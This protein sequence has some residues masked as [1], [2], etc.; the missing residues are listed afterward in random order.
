[1]N[2][3]RTSRS[4]FIVPSNVMKADVIYCWRRL[5]KAMLNCAERW[6]R[7]FLRTPAHGIAFKP[8]SIL[9]FAIL[10]FRWSAK[11]YLTIEFSTCSAAAEW[12]WCTEERTSSSDVRP[13]LNFYQ[14]NL[15]TI[16]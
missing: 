16:P 7:C 10:D 3:G 6:K 13:Q 12:V 11:W 15:R 9:R 4:Y 8:W 14:K 5:A 1:Q 2:V